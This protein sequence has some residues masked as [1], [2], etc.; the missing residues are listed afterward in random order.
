MSTPTKTSPLARWTGQFRTMQ[1]SRRARRTPTGHEIALADRIAHLNP[2]LWDAAAVRG[3]FH[4]RR[5]YLAMLE[6]HGPENILPAYALITRDG[7][8]VAVMAAQWLE[9]DGAR[10]QKLTPESKGAAAA[11]KADL[12]EKW[13]KPLGRKARSK[14]KQRVLVCGNLLSWGCHGV[15]IAPGVDEVEAWSAIGEA[16]YR[17]RRSAKLEGETDFIT[18]KDITPG[19]AGHFPALQ[20]LGYRMAETEP[21]MVLD[22]RKEWRGFDDYAAALS[23]KY[24]KSAKQIREEVSTKGFVTEHLADVGSAAPRLH[25]LYEAV[26]NSAPIRLATL[27]QGFWPAFATCAADDLRCTVIRREDRIVGFVNTVRDGATAIGYQIGFDREAALEAPIYLR[28]LQATIEDGITF[29]CERLS[30]GR[31]ALEPKSRLGARPEPTHLWLRHRIPA[32]NL[33][34]QGII[35]HIPHAEAPERNPFK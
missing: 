35:G 6:Q 2:E 13:L 9:F 14:I 20:Q 29:G 15:S 3:G 24:R 21:N 30:L 10:I 32:M 33:L 31:T 23:S 7:A 22:L 26:H 19:E 18:V 5:S 16:L 12:K 27:S 28:L 34:V 11:A 25:E 17:L 1:D 8:P 4:L